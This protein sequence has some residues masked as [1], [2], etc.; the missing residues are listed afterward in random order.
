VWGRLVAIAEEM[1]TALAATAFSD[2]VREGGDFSIGVFDA[3]GRLVAQA[4]RSPAHLGAMPHTVRHMLSVYPAE[5]LRPGDVVALNDPHLGSGHLPDV[6]GMSPVFA[7]GELVGFV[8]GCVHL[9]D[10]GGMYPGS[11]GVVGISDSIQEG[12]RLLPTLLYKGGRPNEEIFRVIEANVR[13][14]DVVLGDLRGLRNSLH[15]GAVKFAELVGRYGRETFDAAAELFLDRSEQAVRAELERIPAGTYRFVDYLDDT[16]PGTPPLRMECAVSV[17]GSDLV[18]D[19]TG[20]DPQ[21]PSAINSTLGYTRAYCYWV[22]KAITTKDSIPQNEGQLRPVRVIA[23]EG[24]FFNPRRGAPSGG[25]AFL[26]QR[27]VEVIFGALAQAIP[28]R[29][30]A[31]SGQWTNPIFGGRDPVTDRRFVFYDFTLA[32][33]GAR[34]QRDGEDAMSP[35]VSVENMPIEL[36]EQRNPIVIERFELM[37]DSGGAGRTRGGLSVRKDVRPLVD[38]VVVTNLTDRQKFQPYGLEGGR[39]GVLGRIVLNPDTD[40]E[41]ELESKG[42]Y[43]IGSTDV[44]SF[45]CAGSAGFGPPS[46]RPRELV[47]RDVEERYVS[48]EAA[49]E[50]YG[51]DL[52]AEGPRL[53]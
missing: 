23:P 7:G 13:V 4:N 51:L 24:C 20:T 14:P 38:G 22:A 45:R 30:N 48:P 40:R 2:Q 31:A 19:F 43:T 8:V 46:E 10:V 21:T 3:G 52:D 33:L 49:R 50:L 47:R 44:I 29:V 26:N 15:V 11:Q 18:F 16:G 5:S 6:F 25:R 41:Q 34:R 32:G 37:T 39:P 42:I 1:A 12:L 36:Q 17:E 28:D 27:I 35:C 53:T 9:T